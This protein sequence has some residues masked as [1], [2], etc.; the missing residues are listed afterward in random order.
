M[1][2]TVRRLVRVAASHVSPV[3]FLCLALV[4]AFHEQARRF[5]W[6]PALVFVAGVARDVERD[7]LFD[8]RDEGAAAASLA[9][10]TVVLVFLVS[11]ALAVAEEW[12]LHASFERGETMSLGDH[13]RYFSG[14]VMPTMSLLL[15]LVPFVFFGALLRRFPVAR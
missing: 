9:L 10:I 13:A 8:C 6:V 4:F 11:E 5:A 1:S 7:P 14:G 12:G 15:V 3:L 2:E